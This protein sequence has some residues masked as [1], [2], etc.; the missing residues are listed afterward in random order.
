MNMWTCPSKI[1]EFTEL[2]VRYEDMHDFSILAFSSGIICFVLPIQQQNLKV[3]VIKV[4]V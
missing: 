1:P 3:T 2:F 4:Y